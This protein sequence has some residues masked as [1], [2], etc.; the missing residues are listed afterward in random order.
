M[1]GGVNLKAT[2][3]IDIAIILELWRFFNEPQRTQRTQSKEQRRE[4]VVNESFKTAI[5]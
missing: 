4:K 3:L 2:I 1:L 5:C